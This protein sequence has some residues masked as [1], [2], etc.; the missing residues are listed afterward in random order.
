MLFY[1]FVTFQL[2]YSVACYISCYNAP[3]ET[4]TFDYIVTADH[5]PAEIQN[6]SLVANSISCFIQVIWGRDPHTTKITLVAETNMKA[7]STNRKLQVDIGY[8]NKGPISIWKKVILYQCETDQCNSL[9]Q[10]KLLLSSL[11]T[12]DSLIDLVYLLTPSDTPFQGEW[13]YRASNATYQ[14]CN[15]TIPNNLCTQCELTGIMNQTRTELCAI[16][17]TENPS[18]Y[19]LGYDMTFNMTDRTYSTSWVIICK[20]ENCNTPAIGDSI[21]EKSY[22]HFDFNKFLNNETAILSMNKMAL[23]F[24]VFFMKLF[25]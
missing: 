15:T 13:C 16:C 20:Y 10:L 17:S 19:V 1:L 2:V 7:I 4:N 11:T 14:N 18:M 23:L 12:N 24:I 8:E 25:Q 22:I 5:F 3:F 6:S 21:R 9:S